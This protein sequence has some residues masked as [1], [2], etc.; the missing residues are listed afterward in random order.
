MAR[1]VGTVLGV[2]A[3]AAALTAAA[4]DPLTASRRGIC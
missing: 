2:V 3:L 4:A 1:Q